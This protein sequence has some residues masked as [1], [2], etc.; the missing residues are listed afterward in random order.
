[1]PRGAGVRPHSGNS[2][3]SYVSHRNVNVSDAV[4][5]YACTTGGQTTTVTQA[6]SAHCGTW[7]ANAPSCPAGDTPR[8][9]HRHASAGGGTHT[10]CQTHEPSQPDCPTPAPASSATWAWNPGGG[11]TAR[12]RAWTGC[13]T[14]P[15]LL[16][17]CPATD[18]P[19]TQHRH[20]SG[21]HTGCQSHRP[22]P[23]S[24]A[25]GQTGTFA[26]TWTPP[27][28]GH[29]ALARTGQCVRQPCSGW[30]PV[31]VMGG[32]EDYHS[33]QV[34][35]PYHDTG[36]GVDKWAPTA[37]H[38]VD[39]PRV[40]RSG[41]RYT[42]KVREPVPCFVLAS[43]AQTLAFRLGGVLRSGQ[44]VNTRYDH[45]RSIKRD[46]VPSADRGIRGW[47][48]NYDSRESYQDGDTTRWRTCGKV[49]SRFTGL[50]WSIED[51]DLAEGQAGSGSC[52]P[53]RESCDVAI[54]IASGRR[55]GTI[56]LHR[57]WEMKV[58]MSNRT[59]WTGGNT[60]CE[61]VTSSTCTF[62]VTKSVTLLVGRP[63]IGLV[64]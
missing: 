36:D 61:S 49:E 27:G 54:D 40:S 30:W 9:S 12:S 10:D 20:A 42:E 37:S 3:W 52:L 11:H 15:A 23:P 41:H 64:G 22:R 6:Q 44:S 58:T 2:G 48:T 13:G 45:A 16:P 39:R 35:E 55:A 62:T 19:T 51:V 47:V 8:V 56:T 59:G 57:D 38:L 32:A 63:R 7:T 31:D 28:G 5:T 50:R 33:H 60:L 43:G 46:Y 24:C 53:R 17:A 4:T 34:R 18:T 1:M 21:G 14:P 29:A 26:W 25:W